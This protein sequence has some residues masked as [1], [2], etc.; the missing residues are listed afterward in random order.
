MK[1]TEFELKAEV[2]TFYTGYINL[3]KAL[4]LYEIKYGVIPEIIEDTTEEIFVNSSV[5]EKYN[6]PDYTVEMK[7]MKKV[8]EAV[9][10]NMMACDI[11]YYIQVTL[12]V[13]KDTAKVIHKCYI[14]HY[15]ELYFPEEL[16]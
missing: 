14:E 16:I 13:D 9:L 11:R 3:E 15:N 1:L 7:F 6:L 5:F 4:Q 12:L 8:Q 2:L 10:H